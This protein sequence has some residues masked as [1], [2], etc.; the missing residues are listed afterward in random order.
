MSYDRSIFI[1][2]PFDQTYRPTFEAVAFAVL[3]C[4]F[5]PRCALEA[6]DSSVARI[7]KIAEIIA[8]CRLG[9]HDVSRTELDEH[10]GL[11]RFNMPLELGL[12]LGAKRFGDGRHRRKNC[13]ILDRDPH[14]Y[15]VFCSDIAGQDISFHRGQPGRAVAAVRDWLR[16]DLSGVRRRATGTP[17][18]GGTIVPGGAEI[19]R[20][21]E[22][23]RGDLPAVCASLGL[24]ADGIGYADYIYFAEEW[25]AARD[26]S[27]TGG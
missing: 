23:F 20:R 14:R 27:S 7:E 26:W 5:L 15:Q 12:F 17:G 21:Y 24:D 3:D 6:V 9:I 18:G 25:L 2:C 1:N 19:F 13:L 11:P 10:H 4:G 16:S 8:D 22:R